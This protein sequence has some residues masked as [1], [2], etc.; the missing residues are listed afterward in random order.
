[1]YIIALLGGQYGEVFSS[2]VAVLAQPMG[3]T[4]IEN[5][6]AKYFPILRVVQ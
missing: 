6:K 3:G 1:M 2:M 5:P 4:I